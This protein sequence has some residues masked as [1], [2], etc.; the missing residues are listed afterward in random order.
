M[1]DTFHM[2]IEEN[3]LGDAI[4]LIGSRLLQVH[5]NENNR[6]APGAGHVPWT[7]I[8]QALKDVNFDGVLVIESFTNKVKSIAKAAAIWRPLAVSQDALAADGVVFLKELLK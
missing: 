2:N 6:G 8:A 1:A 7:E 5:S 3:S 4:R